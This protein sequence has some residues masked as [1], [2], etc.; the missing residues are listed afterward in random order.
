M[1]LPPTL[2]APQKL[3]ETLTSREQVGLVVEALSPGVV[4]LIR[5]LNGNHVVQRCLQRLGPEDS[6]VGHPGLGGEGG[7][8]KRSRSRTLHVCTSAC[9]TLC[10]PGRVDE[11]TLY[12]CLPLERGQ[13]PAR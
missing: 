11:Q 12:C 13:T 8:C 10:S 7:S 3:I 9:I 6:Q 1:P 5:D 2:P 4:A